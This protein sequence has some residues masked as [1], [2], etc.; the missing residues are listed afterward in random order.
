MMPSTT[1]LLTRILKHLAA[2]MYAALLS[3]NI[4]AETMMKEPANSSDRQLTE[5]SSAIYRPAFRLSV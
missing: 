3:T 2:L 5:K 4:Y 1:T